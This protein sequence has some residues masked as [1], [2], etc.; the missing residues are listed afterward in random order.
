MLCLFNVYFVSATIGV[1]RAASE[2]CDDERDASTE[3]F[4]CGAVVGA[5]FKV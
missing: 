1:A 3:E 2:L 4:R 5:K